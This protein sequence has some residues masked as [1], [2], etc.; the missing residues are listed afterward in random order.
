MEEGVWGGETP[1]KGLDHRAFP[2]VWVRCWGGDGFE[3]RGG[4]G[5]GFVMAGGEGGGPS[6]SLGLALPADPA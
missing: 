6:V 3:A 2:R 1:K 4:L 5:R